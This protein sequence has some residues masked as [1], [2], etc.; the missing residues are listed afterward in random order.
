VQACD[1]AAAIELTVV[2]SNNF[3][4]NGLDR[5]AKESYDPDDKRRRTSIAD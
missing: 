3:P 4:L 2:G 1:L 5:A